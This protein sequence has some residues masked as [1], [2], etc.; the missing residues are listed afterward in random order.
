MKTLALNLRLQYNFY[1]FTKAQG[2]VAKVYDVLY[3]CAI[4]NH[5][6][7]KFGIPRSYNL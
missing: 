5:A 3:L 2:G 4:I 7:N 1:Q 6:V